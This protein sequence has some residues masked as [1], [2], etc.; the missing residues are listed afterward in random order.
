MYI[1]K[2]NIKVPLISLENV[3]V[4]FLENNVGIHSVKD[5]FMIGKRPFKRKTILREIDFTIN[6]G[7][8]WAI[9]GR[10]G[11]GK[12]TLLR[13][14]SGI[15]KPSGG[16]LTVNGTIAPILALGAGVE[17]ELTG[18]ENINL[19]LSLSGLKHKEIVKITSEIIDFS[20]LDSKTLQMPVKRYSS[21]MIARLAFSIALAKNFDILMI[22]EVLAVGDQGFQAKCVQK[23]NLIKEQGK[24]IIF[25]SHAP[26]EAIKICEKAILIENGSITQSGNSMNVCKYYEALFQN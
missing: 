6:R 25:V 24:T 5:F 20:E 3:S 10:N 13:T 8:S 7:E 26:A 18:F 14:I 11:S 21:G 2:I 4:D 15:I 17:L 22:D 19:L 12:S 16:K 9:M 1:D 23:I